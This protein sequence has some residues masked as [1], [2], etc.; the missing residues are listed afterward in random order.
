MWR[1]RQRPTDSQ[2]VIKR[3]QCRQPQIETTT[4][5]PGESRS[6]RATGQSAEAGEKG[7]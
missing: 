3:D 5:R 4:K 1:G 7:S 2:R 6:E